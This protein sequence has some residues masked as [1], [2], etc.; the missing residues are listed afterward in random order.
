[1]LRFSA[2]VIVISVSLANVSLRRERV[3]GGIT[4]HTRLTRKRTPARR[5]VVVAAP[6]KTLS[7]GDDDATTPSWSSSFSRARAPSN[8]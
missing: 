2:D 3:N 5:V 6:D 8:N 1:V 7:G 4:L